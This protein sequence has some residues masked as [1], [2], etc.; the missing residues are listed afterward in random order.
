MPQQCVVHLLMDKG[1]NRYCLN[2]KG[3]SY[4]TEWTDFIEIEG[5]YKKLGLPPSGQKANGCPIYLLPVIHDT[6][7]GVSV[8]DSFLIAEYLEKTYPKPSLFPHNSIAFQSIFDDT[9]RNA[10]LKALRR[11]TIPEIFSLVTPQSKEYFRRTRE[12]AFGKAVEDIAPSNPM[13]FLRRMGYRNTGRSLNNFYLNNTITTIWIQ[14]WRSSKTWLLF[15]LS[16]VWC[17]KLA[18]SHLK[19]T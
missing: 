1:W 11:F 16:I 12:E 4:K 2:Y 8:A 15:K 18:R 7:T 17:S 9:I 3:V 13:D 19:N 5:V 6:S 14:L 10:A